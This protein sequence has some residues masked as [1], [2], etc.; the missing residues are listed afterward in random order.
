[1][2]PAILNIFPPGCDEKIASS[3]T[4]CK[5]FENPDCAINIGMDYNN[6]IHLI[7]TVFGDIQSI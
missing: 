1:M 3:G 5:L 2:S 7:Q 4:G 6:R